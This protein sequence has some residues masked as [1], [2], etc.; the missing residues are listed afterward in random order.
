MAIARS[1]IAR[2]TA[3]VAVLD[4]A[5]LLAGSAA[6]VAARLG[7]GELRTYVFDHLDGWLIFFGSI[8]LA[9]YLAGAY[10]LQHTFSR[11]NLAVNWLFSLTFALLVLSLTSYAWFRLLL[12][13][14]VLA[15]SVACYGA[16]SLGVRLLAY[17]SLFRSRLFLCRV[18]VLG[19]G[20]TAREM[21]RL[22]ERDYVLPAH[23]VMAFIALRAAQHERASEAGSVVEAVALLEA[24]AESLDAVVR[25]LGID[26][27]IV[28]LESP[29]DVRA[30]YPQLRRLRFAGIEVLS[31]LHVEEL[32]SGRTPLEYVDEDYLTQASLESG[33]LVV[34]RVKRLADIG[35]GL[36]ACVFFAPI[37][38]VAAVLIKLS[39]P[40]EPV[41]YFQTRVG[42]FG[43]P[44][45][46]CKFRTMR[47]GAEAETGPVWSSFGDPR[48]T[49][50][51]RI[52]RRFRLDEIPQIVNIL[53]G[54]MSMVGPRP[55]RPELTEKL[56][57]EI[58]Y[59]AERENVVPGLTG[60]AQIRY[61]YG[62]SVDDAA[63]KLEYDMY[64]I[65]HL[66]FSLDVQIVLS[67]L[68]IVLFGKERQV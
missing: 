9:N 35:I 40:R 56:A 54:E 27:L 25:G 53:K 45:R 5:C 22:V 29:D 18:A 38:L 62:S 30:L 13:R 10:R 50:L 24:T 47:S 68:R 36:A 64:Y 8:A 39:A 59:Y 65:K 67:T 2:Q 20:E 23:R 15:L 58:P 52:L 31:P 44:F 14:G 37:A 46:I 17:R 16:L 55:E 33:F 34:R 61:P 60:W 12:G 51:G 3:W 66:S 7:A 43:R 48:V 11:F 19:T 6:G 32:Y 49:R 26:L 42:Q 21:R 57:R 1:H 41:L 28:G 4:M 63:R